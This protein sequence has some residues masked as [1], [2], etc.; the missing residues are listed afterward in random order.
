MSLFIANVELMI[1]LIVAI[2]VLLAIPGS[3][4]AQLLTQTQHGRIEKAA[5]VPPE[6]AGKTTL[7]FIK[8]S[9]Y[10]TGGDETVEFR[11]GDGSTVKLLFP[12]PL[13]WS[14][15]ALEE[16]TQPVAIQLRRDR[17]T[18]CGIS[19]YRIFQ[20]RCTSHQPTAKHPAQPRAICRDEKR[21]RVFA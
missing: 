2:L 19:G 20:R 14:L 9:F 11:G 7:H 1:R 3:V 18:R 10:L 5:A 15:S 21:S 16:S 13:S 17:A 4:H 6:I 8:R 12:A